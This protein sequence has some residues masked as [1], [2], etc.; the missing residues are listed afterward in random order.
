MSVDKIRVEGDP[1]I[2][3]KSAT[4][5][6][7]NYG[8]LLSQPESGT[9]RATI[10]LLHG[11]PDIS[12]GWRYQIP[13]FLNMG[14]RVVAPD[15]LGY[16]RTDAPDDYTEYSHKRGAN[17]IKELA[18]QLGASK[19]IL[20]GH[21]W[22]AAFAYR[23]ALWH[24]DLVTHLFTVCVPYAPPKEGFI[25][26]EEIV[27]KSAPNF[28]YQVQ[29]ASGE[30]EK[31]IK[32]KSEIKQF[33]LS[34]YG[35]CTPEREF[36]FDVTKGVLFDKLP[37]LLPSR[38][39]SEAETEYYATEFARHGM[40]GPLN[41]YRTRKVNHDDELAIL[42]RKIEIPV[43][44]IQALRDGALPPHLGKSM[45]KTLPNLAI[46]RVDT[47]HWALWEKP[48]EVNAILKNW[49]QNVALQAKPSVKL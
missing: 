13:L 48:A 41:W 18:A 43:L 1:R 22:G 35:G 15:C 11:F 33:L 49:L 40:H 23:V 17:D 3:H 30:V 27:Q 39:L 14:L 38:L 2:Q 36:G 9:Y 5:N 16:G 25:P 19:I 21:D 28:M 12:F 29:F 31:V 32:T 8:Y 42:G 46:E 6:G 26:L 45:S 37:R 10:F 4:V 24:P 47:A 44:F 20:G 7:R 34:L